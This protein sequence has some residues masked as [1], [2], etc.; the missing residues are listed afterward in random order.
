MA[1]VDCLGCPFHPRPLQAGH[2]EQQGVG[3]QIMP[4]RF[5]R[6]AQLHKR[7]RQ[8]HNISLR[9]RPHQIPLHLVNGPHFFLH[10][11]G[12]RAILIMPNQRHLRQRCPQRQRHRHPQ[13]LHSDDG[14]GLCLHC[15]TFT[16]K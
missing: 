12:S 4:N 5:Q 9:R 10:L 8:H 15:F 16:K 7:H 1:A 2:I 13:P 11:T 6:L 14:Y 3:L